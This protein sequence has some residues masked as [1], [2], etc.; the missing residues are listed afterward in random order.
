MVS[1]CSLSR[2]Y[3]EQSSFTPSTGLFLASSGADN[4]IHCLSVL[5]V[6]RDSVRNHHHKNKLKKKLK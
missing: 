5:D 6:L 4:N 2:N 3:N 1:C